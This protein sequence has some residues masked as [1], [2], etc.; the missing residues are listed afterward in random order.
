MRRFS[1]FFQLAFIFFFFNTFCV[2]GQHNKARN[3]LTGSLSESS[4]Q[5]LLSNA[6]QWQPFP[7]YQESAQWEAL[8]EEVKHNLIK[9]GEEALAFQ[10]PALPA[11]LYL[12]YS[13]IGNRYNFQ[14]VY[15]ERRSVLSD[16]L[17]AELA[18][19]EGR[20]I[21]QIINGIWAICEESSWCIPAHLYGQKN[22]T[23]PLPLYQEEVVDLFA[24]ETGAALAW[25]YY[26]F[27]DKLDEE[28]PVISERLAYE[29]DQRIIKPNL[30]RNDF[31]WMGNDPER[32]LNNWTPW[33]VSNWLTCALIMEPDAARKAKSVHKAM[34]S[35]DRFL[36]QYPEDGGCDEGPGYWGH[37]GGSLFDCLELLYSASNQKIDIFN[38]PLIKNIGSYIYKAYI[39]NPYY[40][41]F[42]DAAARIDLNEDVVFRYG[43]RIQDETMQ[44]FAAYIAKDQNYEAYAPSNWMG[45]KLNAAFSYN[46]VK[47][48]PA[49][50]PLLADFWLP[51][52]QVYGARSKAGSTQGLYL[53]GK[54]GHNAESHNHNDVGNYI[55]YYNGYPVIIDVGVEE[56]RKETF[57]SERYSIWTMQS[58]YHTLPTINGVMQHQG[59]MYKGQQVSYKSSAGNAH[60]S[61]DIAGAYPEEAE[62]AK[63]VR[64]LNFKRNKSV[65]VTEAYEL[66]AI[67]G[68][69]F[70]SFIT[71][72]LITEAEGKVILKSNPDD[73]AVEPFAISL[74]FPGKE[75]RVVTE[76]IKIEDTRL[77]P[78]WGSTLY[79]IKLILKNPGTKGQIQ[80]T[81]AAD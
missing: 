18:E 74:S 64:T 33:I 48:Y 71:P 2:Y 32:R 58:Q 79:R 44:A 59:G 72:C 56:Y 42:A 80:Y 25:T 49:A 75:I 51:D 47:N 16:L 10:W 12:E 66:N 20:F 70:L 77:L 8:P 50:E 35:L 60:F 13:R 17:L 28:T 1:C 62:V 14:Q 26:F 22:G 63:W 40:I 78:I 7:R 61:I 41:N 57:S 11:T 30:E 29:V 31:W 21:D 54:G 81:I 23:T 24:A 45:R 4:L 15:F 36:N 43:S 55:V 73:D 19:G 37:A 65:Q 68:E 9:K 53:A 67:N 38:E 39:S 3:F 52:I 6:E 46:T 69:T 76:A 34:T 5:T 27:K